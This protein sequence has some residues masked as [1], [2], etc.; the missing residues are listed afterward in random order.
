M[1]STVL[2]LVFTLALVTPAGVQAADLHA[3]PAN[4][5]ST[6]A[7]AKGGDNVNLAS[8]SYGTFSGGSKPSMVTVKPEPGAA[9]TMA[10]NFN[11]ANNVRVDGVIVSTATVQG[12]TKNVTISHS[13]FTGDTV[14]KTNQMANANVVFDG[15]THNNITPSGG[16]EGRITLPGSGPSAS[17]VVIENSLFSGGLSDG[18]QNG[19]N[20]TQILNNEFSNMKQGDANVA[21]TDALQLYGSSNTVIK[22]NY[23]HD[24]EDGIMGPDGTIHEDI[25]NN[26]I[27]T[28]G[29]QYAVTLGSDV[30]STVRHNTMVSTGLRLQQKSGMAAPSGT[31]IRDNILPNLLR[32]SGTAT[33][34]HNLLASGTLSTAD[35]K[36]KPTFSGGTKPTT[37]AGFAL[38][39][40]SA[41]KGTASDGTD[42]GINVGAVSA[43]PGVAG[44]APGAG[45]VS[46]AGSAPATTPAGGS[47]A[48]GPGSGLTTAGAPG[49]TP[50]AVAA[51]AARVTRW[52]FRPRSP[53]AGARVRFA[54]S[55]PKHGKWACRWTYGHSVR[56]GCR[57]AFRFRHSGLKR[58][59][60][61]VTDGA[62]SVVTSTKRVRVLP[63]THGR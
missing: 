18:I 29:N 9:V 62:G 55:A 52:T 48:A 21:H 6:F 14:I 41:G 7:A 58:M 39:A 40:G 42:R 8:G 27:A 38:A 51:V 43:P 53:H 33:Q 2:G 50:A 37:Y 11:G 56:K 24:V 10:I 16:Y 63:R 35:V 25:E 5:G 59:T 47:A 3:T 32:E 46:G 36:G 23:F 17:G 13:T 49:A 28:T 30:G 57:V 4:F 15:N 45:G 44:A 54:V 31:I 34:D 19:S 22:N 20:G 60:L 26:V 1:R 12:A 61:K